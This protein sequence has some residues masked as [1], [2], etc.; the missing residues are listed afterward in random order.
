MSEFLREGTMRLADVLLNTAGGRDVIL[1]LP[2]LAAS[3]DDAEQLGLATPGFQDMVLGPV[4][5]HRAASTTKLLVAAS[6]VLAQ[7]K[8]LSYDSAEVLF[9]TAVGVVIDGVFYEIAESHAAQAN[10]VPYCYWLTLQ[11]P[12]Q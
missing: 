7:V 11:A 12:A 4:V 1:R 6:A 5:F 8:T 3:G 2:G 10:G 9:R